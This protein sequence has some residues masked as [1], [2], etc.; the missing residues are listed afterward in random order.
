MA[1]PCVCIKEGI[2]ATHDAEIINLKEK[3][4][5]L[6]KIFE[7]INVLALNVNSVANKVDNVEK[8]VD[9]V[10]SVV[11]GIKKDVDEMKTSDI[12]ALKNDVS[13]IKAKSDKKEK[14]TYGFWDKVILIVATFIIT[15]LLNATVK[16]IVV[17]LIK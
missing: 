3:V 16:G 4:D 6:T 17:S 14:R 10:S 13:I 11:N 9:K 5:Y 12:T 2:I 1:E 8:N 15:L 7:A